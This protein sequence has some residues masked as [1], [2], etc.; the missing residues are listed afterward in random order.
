MIVLA[1]SEI[2][3]GGWK[4]RVAHICASI[5]SPVNT[6]NINIFSRSY[7]LLSEDVGPCWWTTSNLQRPTYTID[8]RVALQYLNLFVSC[9]TILTLFLNHWPK[10][11]WWFTQTIITSENQGCSYNFGRFPINLECDPMVDISQAPQKAGSVASE[12]FTDHSW[13]LFCFIQFYHRAVLANL[14]LFSFDNPREQTYTAP[15]K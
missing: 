3:Y 14:D 7:H 9:S 12:I 10:N 4:K 15:T 6:K 1:L 13:S 2:F 11:A 8:T 5:S